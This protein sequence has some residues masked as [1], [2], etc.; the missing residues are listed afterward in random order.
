MAS[1]KGKTAIVSGAA[2]GMGNLVSRRLARAG[3]NV[4]LTDV[5]QARIAATAR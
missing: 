5:D 1:F 4:L 2:L 3:A